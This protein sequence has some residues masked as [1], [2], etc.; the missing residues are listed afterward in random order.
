M[1]EIHQVQVHELHS[2]FNQIQGR[3]FLVV[4]GGRDAHGLSARVEAYDAVEE[5]KRVGQQAPQWSAVPLP[6]GKAAAQQELM[7][8]LRRYLGTVGGSGTL[9]EGARLPAPSNAGS[10]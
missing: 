7:A 4:S 6:A 1:L 8:R 9:V 10:Q 5:L 3:R 2:K